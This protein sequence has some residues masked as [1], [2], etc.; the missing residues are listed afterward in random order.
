MLTSEGSLVRTQ[1]RPPDFPGRG[2]FWWLARNSASLV[3]A[4][5]RA[6]R[7]RFGHIVFRSGR[8]PATTWPRRRLDVLRP[9]QQ[10]LGRR[11]LARLQG[12]K[13][14][15]RKVTCRTKT[16]VTVTLRDLRRELDSGVRPSATY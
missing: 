12:G 4:K 15:S 8:T 2:Q 13:A 7:Y 9:R 10:L 14:V 1:L 11:R 5:E 3:R 6:K 16:E